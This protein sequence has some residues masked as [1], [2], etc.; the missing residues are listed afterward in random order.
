MRL[1][2]HLNL[3]AAVRALVGAGRN[4]ASGWNRVCHSDPL[5]RFSPGV[6]VPK[7]AKHCSA[8]ERVERQ[9][10]CRSHRGQP[11]LDRCG[12]HVSEAGVSGMRP[13]GFD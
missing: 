8:L 11:N 3:V 5:V 1:R 6:P 10:E 2:P 4:V 7:E 12:A 9:E 13:R